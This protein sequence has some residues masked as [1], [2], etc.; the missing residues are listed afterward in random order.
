MPVPMW[1]GRLVKTGAFFRRLRVVS[2][3]QA[4]LPK[5]A[6]DTGRADGHDVV[7]EHHERQSTVTFQWMGLLVGDDRLFFP[8]FQ[9]P[10]AGDLGI[11]FVRLAVPFF[12][13][14]EFAAADTEP[15]DKAAC[16]QL[17]PICPMPDVVDDFIAD[18]V[19]N[20]ASV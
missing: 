12:P 1:A 5:H 2:P 13:I 8:I 3:H 9:P 15:G 6:I 10:I 19:G 7:V 14:V 20:P 11:V 17:R 4:R 16:R 18:V